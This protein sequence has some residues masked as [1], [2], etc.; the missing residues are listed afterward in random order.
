[1]L[2][3]HYALAATPLVS[4]NKFYCRHQR[5]GETINE[6]VAI[7]REIATNCDFINPEEMMKDR[8]ILGMSDLKL[9]KKFLVKREATFKDAVEEARATESSDNS[10]TD[11]RRTSGV[12]HAQRYGKDLTEYTKD[13]DEGDLEEAVHRVHPDDRIELQADPLARNQHWQ[14]RWTQ[15]MPN[16][17]ISGRPGTSDE[18]AP[19][20]CRS[21][22]PNH[23]TRNHR[24]NQKGCC[25]SQSSA[26]GVE[27]VATR[28]APNS[29][30]GPLEKKRQQFSASLEKKK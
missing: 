24:P 26:L 11:I 19:D 12:H 22:Q 16:T 15:Q 23:I 28:K 17:R 2:R 9:Q 29:P 18:G 10:T 6:F 5:E 20:L 1:M 13:E 30:P 7:L 8:I 14:R 25:V 27:G 3:D 21:S 4:R